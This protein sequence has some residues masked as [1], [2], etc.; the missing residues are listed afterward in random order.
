MGIFFYLNYKKVAFTKIPYAIT[1]NIYTHTPDIK[2]T[3]PV[4]T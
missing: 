4:H 1:Q 2:R 3:S